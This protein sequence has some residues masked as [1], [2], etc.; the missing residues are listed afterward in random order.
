MQVENLLPVE[1]RGERVLSTRQIADA[2]NCSPYCIR[3]NF[4]ANKQQFQ[5]GI[6]YFRIEGAALK[7]FKQYV[8]EVM[9]KIGDIRNAYA[10]CT[11]LASSLILWTK[12]GAIRLCKL[13]NTQE[14]W[15]MFNILEENYFKTENPEFKVKLTKT[16]KKACRKKKTLKCYWSLSNWRN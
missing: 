9:A 7:E 15:D 5:E 1:Y 8:G 12:R 10:P 11:R 16:K 6:H 4:C 14:A 2:Y 13:V 3:T